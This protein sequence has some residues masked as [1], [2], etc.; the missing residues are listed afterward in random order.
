MQRYSHSTVHHKIADTYAATS[1]STLVKCDAGEKQ[2][3]MHNIECEAVS[4]N[5][6]FIT[7][8]QFLAWTSDGTNDFSLLFHLCFDHRCRFVE[9]SHWAVKYE[10]RKKIKLSLSWNWMARSLSISCYNI[11]YEFFSS[12][13]FGHSHVE[14]RS[15]L[16]RVVNRRFSFIFF[17]SRLT[18]SEWENMHFVCCPI[19]IQWNL[20]IWCETSCSSNSLH[21]ENRSAANILRLI[22]LMQCVCVWRTLFGFHLCT[23]DEWNKPFYT[24][25]YT[26]RAVCVFFFSSPTPANRCEMVINRFVFVVYILRSTSEY[27]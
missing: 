21:A 27:C 11:R 4:I 8:W 2:H 6:Y 26:S 17:L 18:R 24:N 16:V 3:I 5:K 25:K 1:S 22:R 19:H 10:K 13:H 9:D 23:G 15:P 12:A 20:F 7:S 14:L